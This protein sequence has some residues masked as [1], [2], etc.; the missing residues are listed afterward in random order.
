MPTYTKNGWWAQSMV[1]I[2]FLQK[3]P[4]FQTLPNSYAGPYQ[5]SEEPPLWS[6]QLHD[7]DFLAHLHQS[8]LLQ[9]I[10]IFDAVDFLVSTNSLA[11]QIYFFAL[12]IHFFPFVDLFILRRSLCIT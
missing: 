8:L 10:R 12:F 4:H 6:R 5:L 2:E 1:F 3:I 11:L 7:F 9:A